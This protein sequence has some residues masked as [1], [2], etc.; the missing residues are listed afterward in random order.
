MSMA[1]FSFNYL[2]QPTRSY[3]HVDAL[4]DKMPLSPPSVR[5]NYI[6]TSCN[7]RQVQS[8]VNARKSKV[9][10]S[11]CVQKKS[12]SIHNNIICNLRRRD[13]LQQIVLTFTV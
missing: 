12:T 5:W 2:P 10:L 7:Y 8:S 1:A 9:N 6:H 3:V 4:S 11:V 13:V